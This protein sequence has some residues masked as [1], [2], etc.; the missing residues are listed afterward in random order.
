MASAAR[1]RGVGGSGVGGFVRDREVLAVTVVGEKEEKGGKRS[2]KWKR[3]ERER[4]CVC[5]LC[6]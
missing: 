4:E 3:K 2:G 1:T 6:V 5:V